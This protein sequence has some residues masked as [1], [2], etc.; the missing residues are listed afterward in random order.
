MVVVPTFQPRHSLVD[1]GGATWRKGLMALVATN[2]PEEKAV[3]NQARRQ[4]A[5]APPASQH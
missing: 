4:P 2:G 1:L 5:P 3:R